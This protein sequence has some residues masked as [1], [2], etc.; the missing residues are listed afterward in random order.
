MPLFNF[1]LLTGLNLTLS[2]LSLPL[3]SPF[4]PEVD[5][6]ADSF[7]EGLW[8]QIVQIP[9]ADRS[10]KFG[11]DPANCAAIM[12][13]TGTTIEIVTSKDQSLTFLIQGKPAGVAQAEKKIR[14]RF[15]PQ[16][17]SMLP[18]GPSSV[19]CKTSGGSTGG[20][21]VHHPPKKFKKRK[22]IIKG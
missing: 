14:Q 15:N 18:F 7:D 8:S 13:E 2:S 16:V 11:E 4:I 22:K 12:K 20:K 3:D 21:G 6:S 9:F 19:W 5:W 1:N 10:E 17:K